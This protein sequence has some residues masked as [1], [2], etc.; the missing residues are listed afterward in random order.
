MM[1]RNEIGISGGGLF[2]GFALGLLAM[3]LLDPA[4]GRSRRARLRDKLV[5]TGHLGEQLARITQRDVRNRTRGLVSELRARA[6]GETVDDE[7]VTERVRSKIGRLVSHPHAIHI[8]AHDGNIIL[9]GDIIAAE[10]A[11]LIVRVRGVRGVRGVENQLTPH[12]QSFGV[13]ALQGGHPTAT[14]PHVWTPAQRLLA[15]LS[16]TALIGRALHDRGPLGIALG[17]VGASVLLR[18]L[19][20]LP[21]HQWVTRIGEAPRRAA[22]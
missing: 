20:N 9:R 10:V 13:P 1:R 18:G 17:G 4:Q 15:T 7:I 6:Q 2:S 19:T 11:S 3:Y 12:E 16:G 22:G 14:H 21:V 8:E 5:R